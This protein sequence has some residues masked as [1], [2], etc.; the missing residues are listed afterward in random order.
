MSSP[1]TLPETL[2]YR[3]PRRDGGEHVFEGRLLGGGTSQVPGKPRWFEVAIY[4]DLV[5]HC[6]VVYTVGRT[7][8]ADEVPLIRLLETFSAFEVLQS[9]VVH[10]NEKTYL[11]RQSDRALA[12]AAHWDDDIRDAYINRAVL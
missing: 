6:Y 11:P 9:L 3:L 7:T 1:V 12:Q 5:N 4:R 10:H 2:E 8:V